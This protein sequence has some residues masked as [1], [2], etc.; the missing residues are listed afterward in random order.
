MDAATRQ[1]RPS[2]PRAE[3]APQL[4]E[5][6][7]VMMLR[8]MV[9]MMAVLPSGAYTECK[10][11][12]ATAPG[13]GTFKLRDMAAALKDLAAVG[14]SGAYGGGGSDVESWAPLRAMGLFD[15]GEDDEEEDE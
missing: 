1:D 11:D 5:Q 6:L 14:K 10:I 12:L 9:E 13:V 4:I 3:D 2:T 15:D 8:R 7:R